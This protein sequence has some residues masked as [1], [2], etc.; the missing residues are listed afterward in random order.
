MVGKDKQSLIFCA[1]LDK[2]RASY[3]RGNNM[4]K[5]IIQKL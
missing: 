1:N 3:E 5:V 4:Y 2:D